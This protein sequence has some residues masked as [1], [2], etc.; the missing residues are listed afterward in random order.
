MSVRVRPLPPRSYRPTDQ[1]AELLTPEC[2]FDSCWLRHVFKPG[3][4]RLDGQVLCLSS[5]RSR[6]RIPYT[7][8]F[9][10]RSPGP[11]SPESSFCAT[12][13]ISVVAFVGYNLRSRELRFPGCQRWV[14]RP[15]SPWSSAH[16]HP[17]PK[18]DYAGWIPAGLTI[19]LVLRVSSN[20]F[21]AL[22][23]EG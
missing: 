23:S 17:F 18:R 13:R 11:P 14:A 9:L 21:K 20:G 10:A 3:R 8:P 15:P 12:R 19:S 22:P 2:R 16:R 7:S 6:V 4:V 5:R 1:D